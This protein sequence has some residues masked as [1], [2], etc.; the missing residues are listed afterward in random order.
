MSFPLCGLAT[1]ALDA[2][3]WSLRSRRNPFENASHDALTALAV[4]CECL[5]E[6]TLDVA[7]ERFAHQ[8]A[9]S[10]K[11]CAHRSLRDAERG[12][13]LLY[14]ELLERAQHEDDALI[15]RQ[16]VDALLEQT[17]HGHWMRA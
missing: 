14:A 17:F 9:R 1:R 12:R 2:P 8:P 10:E 3:Y 4:K 13:G 11:R 6:R 5:A 15:V 16:R 7:R